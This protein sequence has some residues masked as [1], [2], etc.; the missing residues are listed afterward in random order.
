MRNYYINYSLPVSIIVISFSIISAFLLF[1][2]SS[3]LWIIVGLLLSVS[4][5]CLILT[6]C[7]VFDEF[8]QLT[9]SYLL[10]SILQILSITNL[11]ISSSYGLIRTV[12]YFPPAFIPYIYT[13]MIAILLLFLGCSIGLHSSLKKTNS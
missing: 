13:P 3:S 1:I 6:S 10:T 11:F 4:I 2:D 12:I 5:R 8:Y 9:N 7:I